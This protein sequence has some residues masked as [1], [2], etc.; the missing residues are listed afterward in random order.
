MEQTVETIAC[1]WIEPAVVEIASGHVDLYLAA[2]LE[3]NQVNPARFTQDVVVRVL[4]H[5]VFAFHVPERN[6][7]FPEELQCV[8]ALG[9][10]LFPCTVVL[11]GQVAVRMLVAEVP[12]DA[13]AA[14]HDV[15]PKG[16][17]AGVVAGGIF[18]IGDKSMSG[19]ARLIAGDDPGLAGCHRAVDVVAGPLVDLAEIGLVGLEGKARQ[20]RCV[21]QQVIVRIVH[22][23]NHDVVLIR[24]VRPEV[25]RPG[26]L[27]L[28]C[29]VVYLLAEVPVERQM[30]AEARDQL[31]VVKL[32]MRAEVA[33]V[34]QQ[35]VFGL[36]RF[37]VQVHPD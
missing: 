21:A 33:F 13:C 27:L 28:C 36:H 1:A 18:G 29:S 5:L 14:S 32:T 17:L 10:H 23:V 2:V 30:M 11:A 6:L 24:V 4:G 8:T 35:L 15:S 19:V 31:A 3:I 26:N 25:V 7:V 20:L 37:E 34:Q 9:P 12:F 22:V 16:V